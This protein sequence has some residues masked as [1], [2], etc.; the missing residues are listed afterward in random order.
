MLVKRGLRM[1]RHP[2]PSLG[3]KILNNDFLDVPVGFAQLAQLQQRLQAL[4]PG[5]ADANQNA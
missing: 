1:V 5:L 2:C 4:A 3:T